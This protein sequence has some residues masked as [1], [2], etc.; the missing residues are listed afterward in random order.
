MIP[1]Y[2]NKDIWERLCSYTKHSSFFN[3]K[4]KSS[5]FITVL[6]SAARTSS[7]VRVDNLPLD[8]NEQ[9]LE[10]YFEKWGGPVEKISTNPEEKTA[11]ITFCSQ[12]GTKDVL[13]LLCW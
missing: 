6:F 12:D 11:I 8:A 1:A 4:K 10:L 5:D 7:S 13:I 9:L 2:L 3:E